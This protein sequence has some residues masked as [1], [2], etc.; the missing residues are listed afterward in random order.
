M[1]P[2]WFTFCF[3]ALASFL[4][5]TTKINK[6]ILVSYSILSII[7]LIGLRDQTGSD[8]NHYKNFYINLNSPNEIYNN[9]EFGYYFY[10]RVLNYF[11]ESYSLFILFS[12]SIFVYFFA[13]SICVK[14]SIV[15]T[16]FGLYSSH[17]L[18]L[19]GQSRQVIAV[20]ICALA[21]GYL[22]RNNKFLFLFSVFIATLFHK[23]AIIFLIAYFLLDFRLQKKHFYYLLVIIFVYPILVS[24][25]S[26]FINFVVNISPSIGL[27]LIAYVVSDD[28]TPIFYVEDS[29]TLALI[30]IKRFLFALFFIVAGKFINS[31]RREYYFYCNLYLFST[32]LFALIYSSFPT[33]AIRLALYFYIYD[34]FMFSII[35]LNQRKKYR[36]IVFCCFLIVFAQRLWQPLSLEADFLIP[37][38]GIFFNADLPDKNMPE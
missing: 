14:D 27:Q 28:N 6:I 16:L 21:S 2:Y 37:Y 30:Y 11:I 26:I 19:M 13:R 34:V 9:F 20:S 22:I 29:V 23:S 24:Y 32:L 31:N 10:S 1:L 18:A 38:K 33:I 5:F 35:L 8:W 17:L 15:F 7:I 12:T 3:L 36:F 4:S 25:T